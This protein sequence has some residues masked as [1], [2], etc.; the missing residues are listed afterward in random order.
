LSDH[1][2]ITITTSDGVDLT[3][4]LYEA[5]DAT[6]ITVIHGATGVPYLYY[7]A[8]A[9]WLST[10]RAHNV[11]LYAYRDSD[12]PTPAQLRASKTTMSHW[13]IEDQ[14]AAL[15]YALAQYPDLPL[16][17]IGHS[18]GGFCIPFHNNNDRI[19]THTGVNSGLAYWKA[20][21]IKFTPQV[22][23]FWFVL[24]PLATKLLGYLP[25]QLLGMKNGIPSGVYWQWRQ[26]CTHP[27]FYEPQWGKEVPRPDITRFKGKL[28]L[29]SAADDTII[30]AQR[31]RELKRF[32]PA[33]SSAEETTLKPIDFGLKS[34]GHIQ[35]FSKKCS[36]VWPSLMPVSSL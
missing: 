6:A 2:T 4:R 30:P 18:L 25:G 20:H 29:V 17:T 35:V 16:H 36:A 19:K 5:G 34:I 1:R 11:I 9:Q 26:W 15:D 13:G 14:S 10:E 7:A 32:F 31:V 21:P 24:G 22:V 28:R 27:D 3:G 33:A 8:F 23:L 12:D